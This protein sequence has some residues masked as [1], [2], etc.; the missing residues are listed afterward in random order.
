MVVRD[1]ELRNLYCALKRF[2]PH[3]TLPRFPFGSGCVTS[4]GQPD[5]FSPSYILI[6]GRNDVMQRADYLDGTGTVRL[7]AVILAT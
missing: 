6:M 2:P 5:N 4:W 3:D 7:R 1:S